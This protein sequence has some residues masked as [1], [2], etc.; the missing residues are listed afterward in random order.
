MALAA[1]EG[2]S[3]FR[4]NS[5]SPSAADVLKLT[6]GEES[7]TTGIRRMNLA[8]MIVMYTERHSKLVYQ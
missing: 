5:S 2:S 4:S 3:G 6:I 7:P 8:K 1:H